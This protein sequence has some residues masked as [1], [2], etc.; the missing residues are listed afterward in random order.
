M[1]LAPQHCHALEFRGAAPCC[2]LRSLRGLKN[3]HPRAPGPDK[4][5]SGLFD[6]GTTC[7]LIPDSTVFGVFDESPF[8]VCMIRPSLTFAAFCFQTLYSQRYLAAKDRARHLM[9]LEYTVT[10][11]ASF[12]RRRQPRHVIFIFLDQRP[13]IHASRERLRLFRECRCLALKTTCLNSCRDAS[14]RKRLT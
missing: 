8:Q 3:L 4:A 13:Y 12:P 9:P 2:C 7:N 10:S 5:Y 6:S 11:C 14:N 1:A